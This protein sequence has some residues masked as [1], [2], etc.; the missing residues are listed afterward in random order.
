MKKRK[1]KKEIKLIL[2]VF[3]VI[4]SSIFCFLLKREVKTIKTFKSENILE[5]KDNYNIKVSYP[6]VQNKKFSNK[7]NNLI[8][9][10]IKLF[11]AEAKNL[12]KNRTYELN[13]SFD[14]Y[15]NMN[16]LFTF[17]FTVYEFLGGAHYNRE[18]F[19]YYYDYKKNE[20]IR[21]EDLFIDEQQA[22]KLL[23]NLSKEKLKNIYLNELFSDEALNNGLDS[24][25]DNFE[26][27]LIGDEDV[28]I[29]FP[30]YQVAPWSSGALNIILN[31]N[32]INNLLN[33]KFRKNVQIVKEQNKDAV[34]R[35][36][37]D[38]NKLKGKKLIALT[39]D[40]GPSY[41]TTSKLLD[42]LKSR[43][44]KV[45]FF[46]LGNRVKQLPNIVKRA[47]EEGHTIGSHTYSHKNLFNLE[48]EEILKEINYANDQIESVTGVKPKVI[49]PPYGNFNE[50]IIN[51][52]NMTYILWNIDTMDWKY[53]NEN[54]VYNKILNDAKDGGIIL[55]HD[56]YETSVDAAL[57]AI[58]KLS[59]ENYAFVSFEELEHLDIIKL[60]RNHYFYSIY[61]N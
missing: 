21:W 34:N 1:F 32:E 16:N 45:T 57:K 54:Y 49:R 61:N 33:N 5:Q 40:D 4:L 7:L 53:K 39:F 29:I 38:V 43:N 58:D 3:V 18:D 35:N 36:L 50:H 10:K 19:I 25:K 47:Y 56:L 48:D 12:K 11:K 6:I 2:L 23:S 13:I 46:V 17:H 44:A 30:P 27:I 37:R 24:I 52:T 9:Q 31:Y 15:D 26:L 22:L 28:T 59:E 20:E 60:N 14:I 51:L 42:G 41:N 8:T 55:L